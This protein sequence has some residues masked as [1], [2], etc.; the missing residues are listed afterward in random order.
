MMKHMATVLIEWA[1]IFSLDS[2]DFLA[3]V[4]YPKISCVGVDRRSTI[5]SL[6]IMRKE[7]LGY[8]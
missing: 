6:V 1:Y 5:C 8:D 4:A 3:G 7:L 2:D